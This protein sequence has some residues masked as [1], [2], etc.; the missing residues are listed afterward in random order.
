M[1]SSLWAL[2]HVKLLY[3][4]SELLTTN[5]FTLQYFQRNEEFAHFTLGCIDLAQSIPT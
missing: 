5:N 1:G 3:I 4:S 2:F